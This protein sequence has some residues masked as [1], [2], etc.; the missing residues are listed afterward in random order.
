MKLIKKSD[1]LLQETQIIDKTKEPNLQVDFI[2]KIE[3]IAVE[4]QL[5]RDKEYQEPNYVPMRVN[6]VI[7]SVGKTGWQVSD[8]WKDIRLDSF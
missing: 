3:E 7:L 1:K 8:I 2:N 5:K 6:P 4:E